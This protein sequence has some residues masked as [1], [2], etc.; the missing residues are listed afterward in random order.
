MKNPLAYGKA[1]LSVDIIH[2]GPGSAGEMV[3]VAIEMA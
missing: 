1:T 3:P 2:G